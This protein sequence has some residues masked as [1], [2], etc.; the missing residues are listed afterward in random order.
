VSAFLSL[1]RG[2][3]R[4]RRER[5]TSA[6][7]STIEAGGEVLRQTAFFEN[8]FP[9]KIKLLVQKSGIKCGASPF[10]RMASRTSCAPDE[11]SLI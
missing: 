7:L 1:I 3:Q 8:G 5:Q 10:P 9:S 6:G 11:R 4:A 2:Q